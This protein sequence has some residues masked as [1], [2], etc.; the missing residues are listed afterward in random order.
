V[1]LC[2]TATRDRS[3]SQ[4]FTGSS[5]SSKK[6]DSSADVR[7]LLGEPYEE[8]PSENDDRWHYYMRVRG[9][10]ERRFLGFIPM[11]DSQSLREYEAFVTFRHG[12]VDIVTSTRKRV[13]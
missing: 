2:D 10:E 7:K 6:G 3:R 1:Q 11:P 13:D 12:V 5:W 4:V 8:V 9:A